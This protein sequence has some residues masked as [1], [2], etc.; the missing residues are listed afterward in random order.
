MT[1]ARWGEVKTILASVLEAAPG[2]RIAAIERLCGGDCELR[3][4]VES[5]LALEEKAGELFD[6]AAAP[7]GAWQA[8]AAT[9]EAIG[10]YRVVREIGR[11]GMGVVYLAERA[12]GQFRKLAAVKL[13][14]AS[15]PD[16]QTGLRFQRERQILAQLE[17]PG[18]ARLLDGGATAGGQPYFIMEY[19][20]GLPLLE[21]CRRG[22]LTVSS[23]LRLFLQ[24]AEAVG[25]AHRRLIVHR[26]LKPGNILV[27][28][29]GQAKLLDFGLAQMTGGVGDAITQAGPA[30]MTPAYASPEQIRGESYTVAGDVYSLG[31]ILFELLAGR[32][33]YASTTSYLELARAICDEPAPRLTEA[34]DGA[35]PDSAGL[36]RRLRGDLENIVAKAL[37]KDPRRRYATVDELAADVRRFLEGRPVAA[38]Q[39]TWRYRAARLAARHRMAAAASVLALALILGFAA[40]GWWEARRAEGRFNQ[41]RGLAHAV[42][43][44]IYDAIAPLPGST[45]ARALL[46][47]RALE[48]LE[49]LSQEAGDNRSL[50][51][52]V[53]LGYERIGEV[54][55]D[56]AESSLG[57][58]PDSLESL[59]KAAGILERLAADSPG[60]AGLRHDSLRAAVD[61]ARAYGQAGQ[62]DA[63]VSQ[64]RRAAALAESSA[65]AS[66][67]DAV[68]LGDLEAALADL[69]D[70]VSDEKRYPE[71]I[72]LRER[73]QELAR[74]VAGLAHDSQ[75]SQRSLAVAEKRLAALYGVSGRMEDC[76]REYEMARAIDEERCA[77]N[78]QDMRAKIDLSYDYSDLG[79]EAGATNRLEEA[80]Q[81]DRK[82]LD[83]RQQAAQADP[84][85]FRAATAVAASTRRIGLVIKRMAKPHEA[86]LELE[87]AA[88]RYEELSRR[89]GTDWA[90]VRSLAETHQDMADTWTDLAQA[91]AAD[92]ARRRG[93]EKRAAEEYEQARSLLSGLRDQ[94]KLPKAE[95]ARLEQ[96][97]ALAQKA[98]RSAQ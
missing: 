29:E 89:P 53:A 12:D 73:V 19:V 91:H 21:Y 51:R 13:I 32:R 64:A 38:R 3:G 85:D 23:R 52:E 15:H 17:H 37:E 94:G 43:F 54:E 86:L 41:V 97:S 31:V 87:R 76:R 9:P 80:L 49:N 88:A 8:E 83:L 79:W 71:A 39:P 22:A 95:W 93:D 75:E 90:T 48:Y 55:G 33:P 36:R 1:P 24:V 28:G 27:T 92:A 20:D 66:P 42:M 57:R 65:A 61:L 96:L 30:P 6:S 2:E 4:S 63:G 50:E 74:R 72:R 62:F 82:A 68:A 18:I 78:R 60:D 69:A 81:F 44:E 77:R 35:R 67:G 45:A 59:R 84:Q 58:V 40:F 47:R 70:A 46:A 25:Y 5:L 10:P 34:V 56:L 98:R 11:G 16:V 7:G 26:D 14:T